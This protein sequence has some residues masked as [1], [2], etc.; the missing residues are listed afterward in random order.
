[1][2]KPIADKNHDVYFVP[3]LHRGL[4]VLEAVGR[5][6][7]PLSVT[8]LAQQLKLSRSS[9]FR[10]VYTLQL[11]EFLRP[12]ADP[13]YFGLGARVL[14]LGFTYLAK[15][16]IIQIAKRDLEQL[17]DSTGISTHLAIRD[18]LEMLFLDCIQTRTGF[19]SNVNVGARVPAH[20]SPM[21]WLMLS[22]MSHREIVSLFADVKF[23]KLTARTPANVPELLKAIAGA[24]TAGYVFSR[25]FVELGGCSVA[26][27]VF[28]R[29][30]QVVAA[31]DLSGPESAFDPAKPEG[32]YVNAVRG[33]AAAISA[34]LGYA[35]DLRTKNAR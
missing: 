21:G 29:T 14:S 18:G 25:G 22:E 15:Q 34:R 31:I 30:G 5:S 10:L 9:V 7:K 6:D 35:P 24:A 13:K 8:E 12:A 23:I 20:A 27:P 19:L 2:N 26:A 11:M 16:D 32:F 4:Q 3:G 28:G 17:R 33:A 1:M